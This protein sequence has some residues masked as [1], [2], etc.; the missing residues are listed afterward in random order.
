ML[1]LAIT[2]I[3]TFQGVLSSD[4]CSVPE[5]TSPRSHNYTSV[6][7]LT[8]KTQIAFND[9]PGFTRSVY[10]RDHA[11]ITPE[12]R[13]WAGQPGWTNTVTSHLIS[14]ASG[15]NFAMYLAD[16]KTE[17]A[18]GAPAPGAER[19]ILVVEGEVTVTTSDGRSVDLRHNDYAYFPPH[20]SGKITSAT[21]SGLLIYER[22]YNLKGKPEFFNGHVEGS[23]LLPTPGEV[24]ELRKLIPQT[25]DYDFNI[26]VMDFKPGEHLFVKEVHYNQHGLMMLEGQGIY[27]L[28]D[29]W[30][31]VQSGD[32]VWMAPFVPQ[33][34][35]ALGTTP[36]RYII[37]KDTTVD[38]LMSR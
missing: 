13:V 6:L 22:M 14:P 24:F 7:S 28:G 10:Y 31:P 27:R 32:V 17:S 25:A 3:F 33:W 38:P 15:A 26:H 23:P 21:G 1:L 16:L 9:L 20:D 5:K 37:Y 8:R 35:A 30:Y 29:N 19:F 11:L 18:A 36:T 2:A 4:V 34:Y 12:S